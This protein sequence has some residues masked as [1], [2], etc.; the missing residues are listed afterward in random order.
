MSPLEQAGGERL[1]AVL[2]EVRSWPNHTMR[3]EIA[4]VLPFGRSGTSHGRGSVLLYY[5]QADVLV[6]FLVE[7]LSELREDFAAG[8][9]PAQ[10]VWSIDA[11]IAAL[12][13]LQENP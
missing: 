8:R 7:W 1:V 4:A 3:D 9:A 13:G 11:A 10:H 2:D 12:S 6:A 5:D